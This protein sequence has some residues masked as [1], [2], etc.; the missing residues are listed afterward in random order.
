MRKVNEPRRLIVTGGVGVIGSHLVEALLAQGV[1][2]LV[3]DDLSSGNLANLPT[4]HERLQIYQ[5]DVRDPSLLELYQEYQPEIIFHWQHVMLI[6]CL[7]KT[8]WK[9]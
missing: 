5:R 7:W 8:Q 9:T 6:K 1:Q 2:V 3:I 4:K